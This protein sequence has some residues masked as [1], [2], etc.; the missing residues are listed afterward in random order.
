MEPTAQQ[1]AQALQQGS[2]NRNMTNTGLQ[3]LMSQ[4]PSS[5]MAPGTS[6]LTPAQIQA[7]AQ[8]ATGGF[9]GG[10]FTPPPQAQIATPQ[11]PSIGQQQNLQQQM[12]GLGQFPVNQLMNMFNTPTGQSGQ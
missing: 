4:P 7:I 12:Q 3:A 9:G 6:Q 11:G 1:I 8:G 2:G 10:S 5:M